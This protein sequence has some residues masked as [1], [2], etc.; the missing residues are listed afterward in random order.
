MRVLVLL[1]VASSLAAQRVTIAPKPSTLAQL[2]T[3][4]IM[5][6]AYGAPSAS[7]PA[8][9]RSPSSL[10]QWRVSPSGAFSIK[11]DS[12]AKGQ[13]AT[14]AGVQNGASYAVAFWKHSNGK[15][16][17]DS[18]RLTIGKPRAL[19]RSVYFRVRRVGMSWVGDSVLSVRLG[20]SVCAYVVD[21]DKQ[22]RPI[23]GST[24]TLSS[25]DMRVARPTSLANCPDTTVD[26]VR[27]AR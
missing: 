25:S 20:E 16:Y 7:S 17:A 13:R 1:A 26:P 19:K 5:A 9:A 22:K 11:P 2:D 14:I 27:V 10:V 6:T 15:T 21:W 12:S 18:F 8:G 4:A 3:I 23:T 24:Y